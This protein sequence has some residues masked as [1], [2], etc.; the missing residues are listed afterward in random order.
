MKLYGT[1]NRP[2]CAQFNRRTVNSYRTVYAGFVHNSAKLCKYYGTGMF[3][4]LF[5]SRLFYRVGK[6][7]VKINV[8]NFRCWCYHPQLYEALS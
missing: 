5:L 6:K 1:A 8:I 7:Y 3:V 4:I 2:A